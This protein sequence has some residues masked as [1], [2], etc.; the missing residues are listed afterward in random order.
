[1]L[2]AERS[3][4]FMSVPSSSDGLIVERLQTSEEPRP[5]AQAMAA[6]EPW[7]TLRRDYVESLKNLQDVEKE[8]YVAYSREELVGFLIINMKGA[9]RGYI[10]TVCT[11]PAWRGRGLGS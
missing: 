4:N 3:L 8:V 5:C 6:S 9:L 7:L 2:G 11:M 10:Q 1:M